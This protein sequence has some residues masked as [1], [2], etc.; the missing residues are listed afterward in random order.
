MSII[1]YEY[2][3]GHSWQ[4]LCLSHMKHV[5]PTATENHLSVNPEAYFAVPNHNFNTDNTVEQLNIV[6]TFEDNF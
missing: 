5:C 2:H 1:Q 4:L 3:S 6:D